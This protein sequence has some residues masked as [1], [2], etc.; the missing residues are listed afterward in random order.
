MSMIETEAGACPPRPADLEPESLLLV[1]TAR[2][3]RERS[4]RSPTVKPLAHAAP[5]RA[6]H[7]IGGAHVRKRR[8]R[9]EPAALVYGLIKPWARLG[10]NQRPLA[11]EA[12]A[13][14]AADTG[15][16][17]FWRVLSCSQAAFDWSQRASAV[18]DWRRSR[19]LFGSPPAAPFTRSEQSA[20]GSVTRSSFAHSPSQGGPEPR[21]AR[22]QRRSSDGVS[23][24]RRHG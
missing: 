3:A 8:I 14:G 24:G 17:A 23:R 16:G 1:M 7:A 4:S 9:G 2:R 18:H 20:T 19:K 5:G 11:C 6:T 21:A 10:S 15:S 22:S 13:G 12:S